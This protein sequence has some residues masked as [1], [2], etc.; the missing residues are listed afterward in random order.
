[1][2]FL[3]KQ[4]ISKITSYLLTKSIFFF[5]VFVLL[6][7]FSS[8][9]SSQVPD[10][11]DL[12][13][14]K[15]SQV[16]DK[17]L[18][19]IISQGQMRGL[20][21]KQALDLAVSRGL[22]PTEANK[23]LKRAEDLMDGVDGGR[24]NT[25]NIRTTLREKPDEDDELDF[26]DEDESEI[27]FDFSD[28]SSDELSVF[29]SSL[30]STNNEILEVS[31][32]IPTPVNYTL[33]VGDE[34]IID[35]WG[36][37]NN[38]YQLPIS[39]EGSVIIENIG[40]V[41]LQ[42]LTIKEAEQRL[43]ARLKQ[44]YRGLK[45]GSSDQDTFISISLGN[46]RSIQVT[47]MGEV[48]APGNYTLSSLSSVF[49]ALYKSGGINNVGSYRNIE[50]IRD[51]KVVTTFDLYDVLLRGNQKNNIRLED[52]DIVKVN[53][54]DNRVAITGEIK[55]PA[56]YEI[57]DEE[58]L[59]DLIKNAGGFSTQAYKK[60]LKIQRLTDKEYE[61]VRVNSTEYETFK[62]KDGDA[63]DIEPV[64]SRF[65]NRVYIEGAVWRP[66][67]YGLSEGLTL[68]TLIEQADGLK[69]EAFKT[70]GVIYRLSDRHDYYVTSFNLEEVYQNPSLYDIPLQYEDSIVIRDIYQMREERDVKLYG[71]VQTPGNYQ[72]K[73]NMTLG[74][75]ILTGNGLKA[76]ASESKIEVYRRVIGE[77]SPTRRENKM[78][79][80]F[81]FGI[82]R[83][84]IL[85]GEAK[86][87]ILEPFDQVYIRKRPNYQEQT[88]VTIDGEV[89]YPGEY[90]LESRHQRIS[91]LIKRAGGITD[92]AYVEGI[93]IEREVADYDRVIVELD[94]SR[95]ERVSL[96]RGPT[97]H[98][99]V[100]MAEVLKKPG[101]AD[102]LYLREGDKIIVPLKLQT[103]A[104]DGAVLRAT[105]IKY[106]Q[107]KKINYYISSSGG[108]SE[109]ARRKN[110]YVVYANGSVKAKRNFLFFSVSPK[111]TP[112]AEI[113]VPEKVMQARLTPAER[114]SI[115]TSMVSMSA[116][117]VTAISTVK[118]K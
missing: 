31:M 32:N 18:R 106:I 15:A 27:E 7:P 21:S 40:P 46:V 52:Q 41:Y 8:N 67:E 101:G 65:R 88:T 94:D 39:F 11:S 98:I 87:F 20:T 63:I 85:E 91:D 28:L 6:L 55:R 116:V 105:E 35:I 25:S 49:N 78:A 74:D 58:S 1:M 104:V 118:K 50:V 84:L 70:R 38:F 61:I 14:L 99:G 115:L 54:Y 108:Y 12:S 76:S 47:V 5:L 34:L 97:S 26:F 64:L 81:V 95:D 107:G 57:N 48:E 111:I 16:T 30:F 29:G 82:S 37:S 114:I 79:E 19:S 72:Y 86:D 96:K 71:E 92:D 13:N 4:L 33:G 60:Q 59:Y 109:Q 2:T 100:N 22:S 103:V 77:S 66:G 73:D 53:V 56:Y 110:A 45:P 112:G 69:P 3:N 102:D 62:L 17:Q 44:L 83:E 10:I 90:V 36:A 23:L 43:I 113:I 75:L 89:L 80:A 51:N 117:V 24:D 42:G 68:S 93:S 9:I